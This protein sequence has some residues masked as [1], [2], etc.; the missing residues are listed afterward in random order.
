MKSIPTGTPALLTFFLALGLAPAQD[1]AGPPRMRLYDVRDIV[2]LEPNYLPAAAVDASLVPAGL[3]ESD[4]PHVALELGDLVNFLYMSTDPMYWDREGVE[5]RGDDSGY[6]AIWCDEGMHAQTRSVLSKIRRVLFEPV[7]VELHELPGSVLQDRSAVLS[8][9]AVTDLLAE[10]EEH[11]VLAGR[12]NPRRPLLLE[13]KRIQNRVASF[14]MV[15][16]QDAA[17]PDLGLAAENYGSTWSVRVRRTLDERILVT[18]SGSDRTLT[19]GPV[20]ELPTAEPGKL[21]AV[22]LPVTAIATSHASAYLRPGEGLLIGSD[23]PGGGALCLRI[24][25]TPAADLTVGATT[26]YPVSNLTR[27]AARPAPIRIPYSDGHLL[28]ES[29][30]E[31]MPAVFDDGRLQEWLTAQVQPDTWD[32]SPNTM[33]SLNG[34]L[35]VAA[36]DDTQKGVREALQQLQ[37]IDARQYTLEVAFG[38]VTTEQIADLTD[39]DPTQLATALPHRC[40][41]TVSA[42][43]D[44]S[45]SSTWHTPYVKDYR[46]VIATGSSAASPLLGSIARGFLMQ[47]SVGPMDQGATLLDLR[48]TLLTHDDKPGQLQ[49]A[50]P[51]FARLAK[52][53]VRENTLRGATLVTLGEWTILQLAPLADGS[54]HVAIVARLRSA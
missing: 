49:V 7:L 28:P 9:N 6:L 34:H 20:C 40:V 14:S 12:A 15:V 38:D 17:T 51:G 27:G 29:D 4:D 10:A 25:R 47:A 31:P 44:T 19:R 23:A 3:H 11:G 50:H 18:L 52:V 30:E 45:V 24:R 16:A 42:S 1:A 46:A 21:A 43:R 39:L 8:A 54:G 26:I 33:H 41:T 37:L 36:D 32:G 5:L 2:R 48:M 22:E 53:D 13:S 35:L